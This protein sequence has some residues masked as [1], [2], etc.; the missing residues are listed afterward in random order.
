MCSGCPHNCIACRDL[1][2]LLSEIPN[3]GP[4][5]IELSDETRDAW[6]LPL[7]VPNA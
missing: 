1:P 2:P 7:E 6:D 3:W 5:F 4:L